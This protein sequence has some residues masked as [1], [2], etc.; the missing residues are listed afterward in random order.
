MSAHRHLGM[1][2]RRH[3]TTLIDTNG[4]VKSLEAARFTPV[5]AKAV[6][7]LF[8]GALSST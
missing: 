2:A 7:D 4:L 3:L 5:Q 1:L 6:C 8:A